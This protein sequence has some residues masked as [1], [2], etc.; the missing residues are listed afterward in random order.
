MASLLPYL[1]IHMKQLGMSYEQIAIIYA[2]LPFTSF[3][4]P[5]ITGEEGRTSRVRRV[6]TGL[7]A[8]KFGNYKP[9][10]LLCLVTNAVF[11]SLLVALPAYKREEVAKRGMGFGCGGGAFVEVRGG[12]GCNVS[13]WIGD[14]R[15]ERCRRGC[16]GEEGVEEALKVCDAGHCLDVG[17]QTVFYVRGE[18]A[19]GEA[20]ADGLGLLLSTVTVL[21]NGTEH[22]WELDGVRCPGGCP[23]ECEVTGEAEERCPGEGEE[24]L[25]V[26]MY[27]V[28]RVVATLAM[29][30]GFSLLDATALAM[31]KLHRS[32][33]GKQ[34]LWAL[35]AMAVFSPV[36]GAVV[37]YVSEGSSASGE[38]DYAPVFAISDVLLLANALLLSLL[39]LR[40]ETEPANMFANLGRLLRF[41]DV[42]VFLVMIFVLGAC[43]GYIEAYLFIYLQAIEAPVYLL[44]L[45][46]TVSCVAGVPFL[47]GAERITERVGRVNIIIAAFFVYLARCYGY[48]YITNPW[49]ALPLEALEVFTY[50]LMWV[51]AATYATV[52]APK[53]LLATVTGV[54]G[55]MH[56]SF[57]KGAGTFVGGY[58]ISAFGIQGSFRIWGTTTGACGAVYLLLE[59]TLLKR[60]RAERKRR[61]AV[62]A[63]R[64]PK[65]VEME[66]PKTDSVLA[67]ENR[68]LELVDENIA[69]K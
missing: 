12:S 10:L 51:A 54:M 49:L 22:R 35:I 31:V 43:W 24:A 30:S 33:Y 67:I 27:A 47:W 48:S 69:I 65:D 1:T 20:A 44:G 55:A 5:P 61:E 62:E 4:G 63:G 46:L 28:L 15:V 59:Y 32:D 13:G 26:W 21:S 57:G 16:A 36:T 11:H 9:V 25:V 29:S 60:L 14:W 40:V 19:A 39:D 17:P 66:I 41:P 68:A 56:F 45:T 8:D 37:D 2:V 38:I 3:L 7:I 42:D 64:D 34:R 58:L 18:A 23:V 50:H 53:G 52:I 6:V